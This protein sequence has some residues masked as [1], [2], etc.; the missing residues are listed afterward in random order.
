[1]K[2][3]SVNKKSLTLAVI[4]KILENKEA[5]QKAIVLFERKEADLNKEIKMCLREHSLINSSLSGRKGTILWRKG[6]YHIRTISGT[7][8]YYCHTHV[9][10][11]K[12]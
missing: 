9:F 2:Q 7:Y 1:M 3:T 11:D 4:K 8:L 6:N 5:K 12:S 10:G